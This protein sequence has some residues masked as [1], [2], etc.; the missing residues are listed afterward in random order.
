MER[1][2]RMSGSLGGSLRLPKRLLALRS[3]DRLVEAFRAGDDSA[4]EVLYERHASGVLGFC[5][6][7]LGSHEEA[8]DAVQQTFVSAHR[9]LLR[10]DREISFKAWLFTIA[11]NASLSML[12][13]RR[14]QASEV[15][16]VPS[17]T[18]LAEEVEHRRELRQLL[19]GLQDLPDDQRAALVLTELGDL[20]HAEVAE[21]LGCEAQAVKGVLF[22]ARSGLIERR[23]AWEADCGEIREELAVARGGALRRG[24]LRHHLAVCSGCV[25]YL[26][27]VQRQ[28]KLFAIGLPVVPALALK[29]SIMAATGIGTSSV[30]GAAGAGALATGGAAAGSSVLGGTLAKVAVVGVLVGGGVATEAAVDN[31]GADSRPAAPAGIEPGGASGGRSGIAAPASD[32]ASKDRSARA[33]KG[34]AA[35]ERAQRRNARRA[36]GRN[37]AAGDNRGL[38]RRRV[39]DPPGLRRGQSASPP[40]KPL[41]KGRPT[42]SPRA[43]PPRSQA[44][45]SPPGSGR[46]KAPTEAET[47]VKPKPL[48][49]ARQDPATSE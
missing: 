5:R 19:A 36:V 11:R 26:E 20:S 9:A 10:D 39:E 7:M 17:T 31:R 24:R 35:R 46:A 27:E 21:V 25:A 1:T 23:Q 14:E 33:R 15:L 22:R 37:G 41:E 38:A 34:A 30:A 42:A 49:P 3:D 8:E 6:H 47:I 32:T 2:A 28:R 43:T 48:P 29:D 18:G 44:P 45:S 40:G 13:A 12:R 16:E 4:F